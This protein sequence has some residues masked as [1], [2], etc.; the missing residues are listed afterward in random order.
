MRATLERP[1]PTRAAWHLNLARGDSGDRS[2][3]SRRGAGGSDEEG[4]RAQPR[5]RCARASIR[6]ASASIS[7]RATSAASI[8]GRCTISASPS[9]AAWI[10]PAPSRIWHLASPARACRSSVMKRLW[11]VFVATDVRTWVEDHISGGTVERVVVAG[12]APLPTSRPTV[13][14]RRRT[15]SRSISKPAAPLCV[16]S[17]ICRRSAMPISPSALPA[18][19]RRSISAAAPSKSRRAA[20]SMSPAAFSR[21]PTPI[22]NRA[23]ARRLSALMAPCRQL[24]LC[25]PATACATMSGSRSIRPR[26][27]APSRPRSRVN[28]PLAKTKLPKG[29][30][31]YSVTADLTNFAADKMLLGQK[32][33]AAA[34]HVT[35]VH[36]GYQDQRRRQDQRHAGHHRFAQAERRRRRRT[37]HAGHY[38]R[39]RAPPAWHRFRQCVTGVDPGQ[40]HRP[41]RRQYQ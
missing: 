8:R 6:C 4:I 2:D 3:H 9:P 29:T 27:A 35:A 33:E 10:I 7:I 24:R 40:S 11:P 16:R 17:T 23:P 18:A 20:S 34:L 36:D 26:A 32:V 15:G 25:W 19:A 5:Q 39:S 38:R 1:P 22:P 30:A 31:T 41:R 14:R 12:N 21:C 13:R 28:V 37:A